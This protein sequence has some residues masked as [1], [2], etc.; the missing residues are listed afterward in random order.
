M[1]YVFK[2]VGNDFVLDKKSTMLDELPSNVYKISQVPQVGIVFQ[3]LNIVKDNLIR[4]KD[5][6]TDEILNFIENFT[7]VETKERYQTT[8][9]VHKTGVLLEG[10]PGSGKSGCLNMIIDELIKQDAILFFDAEP[11]LVSA[12]LPAVREQNPNKLICVIYE[13]FDEWLKHDQATINSFL[14]GQLSVNNMIVLATTNYISK[15]PSRIKNRPSRFQLVKHVGTPTKEFRQAWFEQKLQD[16][17]YADKTAAFVESSEG[18][19][20]DQMKDMIVSH[21][22][23]QIPLHEV[24]RKL[25]DMSDNAAGVDDYVEEESYKTLRDTQLQKL[26]SLPRGLTAFTLGRPDGEPIK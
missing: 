9:V 17:G 3:P 13:E 14:D 8:K 1:S 15:I 12:V 19:V 24:V 2:T 4:V 6:V 26:F 18:M 22:A 21:I 5:S 25:Q 20:I 7:A 11:D 23:L 10:P 16:I